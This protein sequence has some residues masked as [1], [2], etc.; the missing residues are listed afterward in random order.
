MPKWLT[1]ILI[2]VLGAI[3]SVVSPE[4]RKA[5]VDFVKKLEAK[6]KETP[7]PAD[8]MLVDFLKHILNIKE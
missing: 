6:A 1:T 5:L 7:N 2:S 8:D 3:L 4:I